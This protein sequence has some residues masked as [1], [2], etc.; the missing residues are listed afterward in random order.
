MAFTIIRPDGVTLT[1]DATI[2]ESYDP[3]S[4]ATDHPVEDGVAIT[5]H[6]QELPLTASVEALITETPHE[7]AVTPRTTNATS[8][9]GVQRLVDAVEFLR[10]C[11]GQLLDIVSVRLGTFRNMALIRYPHT[12]TNVRRLPFVMD[13]RQLRVVSAQSVY[14]PPAQPRESVNAGAP[15]EQDI[16]D[17]ATQRRQTSQGNR[18]IENPADT[19]DKSVAAS[20]YD[21][22]AG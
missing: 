2:R 16:G 8:A 12:V 4:I 14:I 15:D 7:G 19:R 5:D 21:A 1:F 6:I 22:I 3:A 13:F 10:G 18:G 11:Q 20:I 17:Q 9:A